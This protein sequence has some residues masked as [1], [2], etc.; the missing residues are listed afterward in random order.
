MS[1]ATD[2]PLSF[3]D[4][5]TGNAY[6][7]RLPLTNP[8]LAEEQLTRFLD[9][10]MRQ[11]PA[12]AVLFTLVEQARAPLHSVAEELARGYHGKPLP[13]TADEDGHFR[14]VLAAWGKMAKVYALCARLEPPDTDSAE[15]CLRMA[16]ILHRCLYYTGMSILEH[17]RA[18]RELPPGLWLELHGYYETAEEWGIASLP[19]R[20][21][22][23]NGAHPSH[24]AAVYIALMLVEVASPY[25][26][27][28]RDLNLI[29][30]WASALAPLVS[31]H[32][33][34]DEFVVPPYVVEL[35]QDAPLHPSAA[36]ETLGTDARRFDTTRLGLQINHTLVQLHQRVTPRQLGLGEGTAGHVLPLLEQVLRPWTQQASP[37]KFRRFPSTG[38]ARVA[39]GFEAM[40]YYVGGVEF[41][42]AD[43]A[44]TYSRSD[45]DALFTFREQVS[46]GQA[47]NIRP[48]VA[49]GVDEWTVLNHSAKGFLLGRSCVGQRM[50]QGQ[51]VA[52]CPHDGKSYLLAQVVWLMQEEAD[53]LLAGLSTLPGTPLAA[54]IRP[55]AER[56]A[57]ER[58][59]RGFLLPALPAIGEEAA[60][61]AP[62]GTYQAGRAL[63]VCHGD[64]TW[65]LRML[66]V[67]QR[68]S[69]FERISY[70]RL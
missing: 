59:E 57:A 48:R 35:M 28:I 27:S 47:L 34:D 23:E 37:R 16:T 63:E 55:L 26:H 32:R 49:Y 14:R 53:G 11:P 3:P 33:L 19:V 10:L 68:G 66:H 22:L 4:L 17:F 15:Y 38:L 5:A 56:G 30:R 7:A 41:V 21:A 6:L 52:V 25:N 42:Q 18:R 31:I 50:L 69:D 62:A 64:E 13:L 9:A 36:S 61:V 24:C 39:S 54:G 65:Q 12:P 44:S 45:F 2:A 40:H 1:A 58:Y 46:P 43:A 8:A 70:Q 67:V 29:H 60:L 51:L 20:D